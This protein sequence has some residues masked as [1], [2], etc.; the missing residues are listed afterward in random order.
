[1]KS[2]ITIFIYLI[3]KDKSKIL[4]SPL[5]GLN[6]DLNIF[7]DNIYTATKIIFIYIFALMMLRGLFEAAKFVR[8][9]FFAA[10]RRSLKRSIYDSV[11]VY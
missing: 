4:T 8:L 5:N 6:L 11:D 1:M 2:C 3:K 7:A 10:T 9:S